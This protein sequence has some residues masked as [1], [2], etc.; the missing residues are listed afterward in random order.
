MVLRRRF[1][2]FVLELVDKVGVEADKYIGLHV[3]RLPG[4]IQ[5]D[6]HDRSERPVG[7]LFF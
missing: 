2:E 3:G 7:F 1:P 4:T 5:I 6:F